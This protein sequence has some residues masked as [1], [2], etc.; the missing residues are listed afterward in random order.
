MSDR[1]GVYDP[2]DL[3]TLRAQLR[4]AGETVS[5]INNRRYL[6]NKYRITP[7]I[8]STILSQCGIFG[9]LGDLFSGTGAVSKAFED[10]DLVINDIL[11]SNFLSAQCWFSSE[12]YRP[13]RILS[14][15]RRMNQFDK[16]EDNYMTEAYSDTYFSRRVCSKI[17]QAREFVR[18]LY[19]NGHVNQRETAILVTSILYGAD[20]I[21]NTVGHYDA[22]RRGVEMP[23]TVVFPVILPDLN[24]GL[25]RAI[26]NADISKIIEQVEVDVLY[27]DPPYNSRQYSDTYHVLENI[28]RWEKPRVYGIARKMDRSF[29]KSDFNTVR[30]LSALSDI[31][32]KAKCRYITLSYNNMGEHGAGRSRARISDEDIISCLQRRGPVTAAETPHSQFSTG[33]SQKRKNMERLFICEIQD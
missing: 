24:T 18:T 31:V 26:Y 12:R 28:A 5:D 27:L 22:Y 19:R 29:I 21:A 13:D 4:Q 8:R 33:R 25:K 1:V 10:R 2:G 32:D 7:F 17:G 6:G 30:A 11:R 3:Q 9:S 23:E 16:Y 15:I 14:A 20:K